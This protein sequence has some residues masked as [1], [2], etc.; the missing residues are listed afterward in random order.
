M[1]WQEFIDLPEGRAFF[2]LDPEGA[3]RLQ[4]RT[5]SGN[6]RI[7]W[8]KVPCPLNK[9]PVAVVEIPLTI[10]MFLE[11]PTFQGEINLAVISTRALDPSAVQKLQ[12]AI[13]PEHQHRD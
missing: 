13:G 9:A 12:E 6:P 8:V 3:Q 4:C 10:Y 5:E 1:S 2:A 11:P 7:V